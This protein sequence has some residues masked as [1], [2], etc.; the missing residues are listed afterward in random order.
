MTFT[1]ALYLAGLVLNIS[2]FIA[3]PVG[4]VIA[5]ADG[6][7]RGGGFIFAGLIALVVGYVLKNIAE[8]MQQTRNE[9]VI[10]GLSADA[11][12]RRDARARANS[13]REPWISE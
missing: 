10:A 11:K 13:E 8:S 5:V 3:I 1:I 6:G 2:G 12:A 9:R 7:E 4:A